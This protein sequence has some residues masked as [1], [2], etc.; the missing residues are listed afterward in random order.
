MF[1]EADNVILKLNK[2]D[3]KRCGRSYS[4]GLADDL[5][6][7]AEDDPSAVMIEVEAQADYLRHPLPQ[8]RDVRKMKGA[9]QGTVTLSSQF[10]HEDV[11]SDCAGPSHLR[12]R[13][14][15]NPSVLEE[16]QDTRLWE[17]GAKVV[18]CFTRGAPKGPNLPQARLNLQD[19]LF[20]GHGKATHSQTWAGEP[21]WLG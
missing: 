21:A 13:S 2:A 5:A 11:R 12:M 10:S 19:A 8:P 20:S 1:S 7:P 14:E 15:L 17:A 18:H 16:L 4:A 3:L 6:A 9:P